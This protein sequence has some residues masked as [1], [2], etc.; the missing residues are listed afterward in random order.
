[1][2][3]TKSE[4]TRKPE[5]TTT[6]VESFLGAPDKLHKMHGRTHPACLYLADRVAQVESLDAFKKAVDKSTP[7]RVSAKIAADRKREMLLK[8][9]AELPIK[10][11]QNCSLTS[12][13]NQAISDYNRWN[14]LSIVDGDIEKATVN[15]DP[16]FLNRIT[17]NYIRHSCMDYDRNLEELLGKTGVTNAVNLLRKR[18]YDVISNAYK[19]LEQECI[20]QLN[21]RWIEK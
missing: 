3:L 9:V 17:V 4:I 11:K 7:R 1:M 15:S 14:Y 2:Y 12:V 19:S 18:I 5:W 20:D 16:Q 13:I 8:Q 21:N 10:I 6:L